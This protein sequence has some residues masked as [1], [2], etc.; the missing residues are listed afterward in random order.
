MSWDVGYDDRWQRWVG[1]GVPAWC[2]HPGCYEKIHR[3]LAYICGGDIYGGDEGCGLFFCYKHLF[4]SDRSRHQLCERCCVGE[5][6][7]NP[8]LDTDEWVE[9]QMTDP[10]WAEWRAEQLDKHP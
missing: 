4:F 6:P 2:D 10:S 3:G 1:Y 5:K 9:H 7:F 8:S